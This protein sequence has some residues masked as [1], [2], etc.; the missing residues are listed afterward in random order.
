MGEGGKWVNVGSGSVWEVVE[1][2]GGKLD[3]VGSGSMWEV[4]AVSILYLTLFP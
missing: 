2:E 1:G 3:S 4:G